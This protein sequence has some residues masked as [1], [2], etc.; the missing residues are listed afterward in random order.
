ML[1]QDAGPRLDSDAV[2][3]LLSQVAVVPVGEIVRLSDGT[4]GA[5]TAV[6]L[7][8]PLQPKVTVVGDAKDQPVE[9]RSVDL[10]GTDIEV[11][12]ILDDW[13][14]DFS[15]RARSGSQYGDGPS[16]SHRTN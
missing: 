13:P 8:H 9:R 6:D 2:E 7:K 14:H 12:V 4:L 1:R 16:T 11:T 5:V 15:R 10:R 3:I